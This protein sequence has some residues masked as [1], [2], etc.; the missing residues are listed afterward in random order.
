MSAGSHDLKVD[1][2]T[3]EGRQG[4]DRLLCGLGQQTDGRRPDG[5]KEV[6]AVVDSGAEETVAPPGLLPGVVA[7]SPMQRAGGRYRAANGARIPNLGQQRATFQ[8]TDGQRCSLLFQ[9]AGV[10]RPLVSVSQ[11]VKTGHRVEFGSAEGA[12]VHQRTGRKIRLQRVGGVFVLKMRIRDNKAACL[13]AGF[14][15]P[16]Q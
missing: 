16:G 14:S 8:T 7:E 1:V 5:W 15:R 3:V 13:S 4:A 11:L 10:E 2:L 9:V 12:I 6:I